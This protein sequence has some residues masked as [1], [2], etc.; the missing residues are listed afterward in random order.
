[1]T[2]EG[3]L[4]KRSSKSD[5]G[6]TMRLGGQKA[7]L[8]KKSLAYKTYG[9]DEIVERHRHRYEFNNHY[10]DILTKNGLVISGVSHDKTLVEIIELPN[11]PWFMGCQSHPEFTSHP[12]TGHPFFTGF[13]NAALD[14]HNAKSTKSV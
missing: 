6:G 9:T 12:R 7:H 1:M 10:I 14:F 8:S 5:M 3:E 11:H 13:I 4:E 2:E